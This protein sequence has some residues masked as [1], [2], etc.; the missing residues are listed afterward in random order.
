[1]LRS[2]LTVF[3]LPML[4]LLA[5]SSDNSAAREK[6]K[7]ADIQVETVEK[8][9]VASGSATLDL[10][11][12][13]LNDAGLPSRSEA[14]AGSTTEKSTLET[15]H[16]ALAP[17]SFFTIVVTN[18]VLRTPLPGAAGLIPQNAAN[19]PPLLSASFHQLV[20]E[21][22][23]SD[24]AFALV[25]RDSKT[26]FIFFNIE[27]YEYDYD[28]G[29]RSLKIKGGRLLVSEDF[30]KQLGRPWEA[31]I[32]IGKISVAASMSQIEIKTVVNGEVQSAVLPA[33]HRG[34][35]TGTDV[36]TTPGPDVIVGNISDVI[37]SGSSV[38]GQVGVS[39]G[40]DSCN[41]GTIDLDW[42]ALR[43]MTIR[44]FPQNL[45]RMSGGTGNTDRFEQ[46]GQSW[47]KHA[48]T[49]ASS[50]TCGFGC[51]GVGGTHLGS[52]C[53][54]LYSAGLNASQ[55]GLGSRAWVNPFTGVYPRGDSATPPSSH[56]GHTHTDTSH[57]VLVNVSDLDTTQNAGATYFRRRSI[58][59]ST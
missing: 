36:G 53:S 27:G 22:M 50:N 17:D 9:I 40:T 47:L 8:L 51:N 42:F 3:M 28:A 26:G 2:I 21:N 13:R 35:G 15:L 18:D 55:S 30:A 19:L 25:V 16:F 5:S 1:M 38:S 52:G 44:L 7:S 11:L 24:D 37:Q 39:V 41:P 23:L 29:A 33:L 59:H 6:Q 58:R 57:R 12:D 32:V 54:D 46:I 20:L 34:A 45:Y 49:A 31:R 14:K 43:A 10:D 4:L 48:F 56:T